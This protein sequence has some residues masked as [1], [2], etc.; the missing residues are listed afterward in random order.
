[1][2]FAAFF[3]F[4]DLFLFVIFVFVLYSYFD[5]PL[6]LS[7]SPACVCMFYFH[8]VFGLIHHRPLTRIINAKKSILFEWTQRF[9]WSIFIYCR[10]ATR[11]FFC[12][13]A[14]ENFLAS[15]V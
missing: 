4:V 2:S 11:F 1:M 12:I 8:F 7:H 9:V 13:H 15:S 6:F 10:L 14:L 5:D 3:L